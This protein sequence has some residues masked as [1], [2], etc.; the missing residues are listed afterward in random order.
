MKAPFTFAILGAGGR[1]QLFSDWLAAHSGAGRVVAVADPDPARRKKVADPHQI[2]EEMQ[3]VSWEALLERPQLADAIINTTMDRLHAASAVRAMEVG[4]HML[5]EKPMAASYEDCLA[6]DRARRKSGRIVSVCHTMR[7]HQAYAEAKRLVDSGAIGRLVTFDH[8]EPVNPFH[9]AHSFVRGNWG[10]E[11]R[12]SFLLLSKSCHDMDLVANMVGRPCQ[13]VSSFG[14]LSYF[15]EGCAPAGA[16]ARCTDGCP[17]EKDCSYSALKFYIQPDPRWPSCAD[18]F[19]GKTLPEKFEALRTGPY[20]RCVFRCDN[21]VVDHQVVNFEFEGGVTGTFTVTAF[22]DHGVSR[23]MRLHGT[24]GF[25]HV[26]IN[27][28]RIEW[29]RYHDNRLA[30]IQLPPQEGSHGGGDHNLMLNFVETI[31]GNQP[32]AVSTGTAESLAS[33]AIVFAAERSRREKRIVEL[34]EFEGAADK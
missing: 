8:L 4:Y 6:I 29:L 31:K 16:P 26:A 30:T 24:E 5:L 17:V 11:S 1:G 3:F 15:H 27:E 23:L 18:S 28:N 14:S 10:N 33:H 21:D 25:L 22:R 2:P 19:A 34:S 7:Y 20:G 13:R 32:D 9:Q 12:S